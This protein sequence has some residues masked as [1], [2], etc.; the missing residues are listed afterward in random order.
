MGW[1]NRKGK[2]YYYRKERGPD[3]RVRSQ[4]MGGGQKAID[5]SRADGV[6][7]P[8]EVDREHLGSH[9]APEEGQSP[10]PLHPALE[11]QDETTKESAQAE[12][13]AQPDVAADMAEIR[14][15]KKETAE[16]T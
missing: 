13:V 1:E 15:I 10:S 4:Y 9:E 5:A 7:V 2:L 11:A 6:P 14:H 12:A 8:D 16:T 3:G